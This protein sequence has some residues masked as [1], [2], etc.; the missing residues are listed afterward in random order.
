M[1]SLVYKLISQS[2]WLWG[3]KKSVVQ[4]LKCGIPFGVWSV[5]HLWG[6][7]DAGEVLNEIAAGGITVFTSL[8]RSAQTVYGDL[9][10]ITPTGA[11]WGCPG[12]GEV[13]VR[14]I[15]QQSRGVWPFQAVERREEDL[16]APF[17]QPEILCKLCKC[18]CW[19]ACWR[20]LGING[21]E[22]RGQPEARSSSAQQNEFC[23][24]GSQMQLGCVAVAFFCFLE[25]RGF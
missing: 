22:E 25:G 3:K 14:P 19:A 24:N 12:Q 23:T 17:Q 13:A 8:Y 9:C 4:L 11:S 16:G 5:S 10:L 21:C 20:F 1:G 2:C 6:R 15:R 18:L 7:D